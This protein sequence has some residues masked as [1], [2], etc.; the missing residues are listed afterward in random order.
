MP[1]YTNLHHRMGGG[2]VAKPGAA[3]REHWR[4]DVVKMRSEIVDALR[5]ADVTAEALVH[6][7][8][9]GDPRRAEIVEAAKRID[10]ARRCFLRIN[11]PE[12]IS[13]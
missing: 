6:M 12:T 3:K 7:F 2:G 1:A 13:E 9:H 11:L 5:N 10:E 8:A 4:R